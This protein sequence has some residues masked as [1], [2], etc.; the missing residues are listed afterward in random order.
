MLPNNTESARIGHWGPN[1]NLYFHKNVSQRS[2]TKPSWNE[3]YYQYRETKLEHPP[4]NRTSP[5][6]Q[7]SVFTSSTY[8][9]NVGAQGFKTANPS[10]Q[11]SHQNNLANDGA[12]RGET[13]YQRQFKK[14]GYETYSPQRRFP[15][16]N[17]KFGKDY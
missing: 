17:T 7:S 10:E 12:K 3:P 6:Y 9:Y 14:S 4:K 5:T 15:L 8:A 2:P 16:G 1:D 13:S 11:S